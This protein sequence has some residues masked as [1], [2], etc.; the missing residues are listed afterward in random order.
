MRKVSLDLGQALS[1]FDTALQLPDTDEVQAQREQ[2][3]YSNELVD[4]HEARLI[5]V[6]RRRLSLAR[7]RSV[8]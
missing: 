7:T 3:E 5:E 4:F 8:R 2:D 1:V 6:R